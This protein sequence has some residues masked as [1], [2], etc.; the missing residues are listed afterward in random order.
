MIASGRPSSWNHSLARWCWY[1]RC[2]RLQCGRTL[3]FHVLLSSMTGEAG[4]AAPAIAPARAEEAGVASW[5]FRAFRARKF[6][7]A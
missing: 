5:T 2:G 7:A 6:V 4:P 3:P 1:G